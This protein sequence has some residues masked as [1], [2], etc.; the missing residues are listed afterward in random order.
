MGTIVSFFCKCGYSKALQ[1]G[2]GMFA[3][4]EDRAVACFSPEQLAPYHQ[5][6][7]NGRFVGAVLENHPALCPGCGQLVQLP[8][9]LV[10]TTDGHPFTITAACPACG[11]AAAPAAGYELPCPGCGQALHGLEEG[12]WD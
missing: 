6:K 9:L 2:G 5:A 1:L 7:Q 4:R 8:V 10:E 11:A 12:R 3:Y